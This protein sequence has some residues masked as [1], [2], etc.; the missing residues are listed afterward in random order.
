MHFNIIASPG[1]EFPSVAINS[2]VLYK[3]DGIPA[4]LEVNIQVCLDEL[5]VP[6]HTLTKFIQIQ[7]PDSMCDLNYILLIEDERDNVVKR[8]GPFLHIGSS[9]VKQAIVITD[10]KGNQEYSLKAQAELHSQVAESN[11][12]YFS[13]SNGII[14]VSDA[15]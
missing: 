6:L 15:Y 14:I 11:K 4:A 5:L 8:L 3:S 1:I 13:K 2:S 7:L 10:L 9:V 12:H